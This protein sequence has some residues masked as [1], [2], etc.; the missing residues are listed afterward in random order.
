MHWL[1]RR[2]TLWLLASAAVLVGLALAPG[3]WHI[4]SVWG[5]LGVVAF[6]ASRRPWLKVIA[7]VACGLALGSARGALYL[8]KLAQYQSLYGQSVTLLVHAANDAVYGTHSQLA[9]DAD[10]I[11]FEDGQRLTGKLEVS[12]FGLNTVWQGDEIEVTGK[13]RP[14]YGSFQGDI[15]FAKLSL[16]EHQPSLVATIRRKFDAGMQTALPEPLAPFALGLLIGQ[17]ATL[18]PEIK[19]NLLHV[20][21]THIIAVSGYNLTII[22]QASGGMLARFSKRLTTVLSFSLIGV[23]LL[24]AGSSAS[25]VRAAIV[26]ML[27]IVAKYYGRSFKPLNLILLAAA[28]TAWANPVYIWSDVSWYLSFLAFYGVLVVAPLLQK[29]WP[30]RGFKSLIG[31]VCLETI[32]AEIMSWPYIVYTFGQMSW[33]GLPANVLV[34][35]LVPLA[36]LLSL[37]AGL[38]GMLM[39]PLAGWLAWPARQLLNYMLDTARLLAGIP[40]V[41]IENLQ[42]PLA[43]LVSFYGLALLIG[44]II[45]GKTKGPKADTITDMSGHSKWSTIKREKG[46]KDAARGALFTKLGNAIAIAARSGTDPDTNFALRLAVEKAK[47]SNMPLANI[48]RSIDRAKDKDAAQLQEILYEGYGPG[49]VAILV[50]CATDNINRTYPDVK[51]A[52]AKHGGSIAD[53]GSVAFQFDR[54]GVIRVNGS[55]DD[56]L[57][58]ALDAGAEDVQEEGNESVIY[59]AQTDLAKVR[60]ALREGGLEVTEAELTYVPNNTVEIT[61]KDTAGKIM[62]LMDALDELDDVSNTHVNF[63]IDESLL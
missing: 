57:M 41:F 27:S 52:F 1:E 14:G 42:L 43:G 30:W 9:F 56:V 20:G 48:Q 6:L 47:S 11:R 18:P 21:L 10:Q 53:K 4:G 24:L 60:D 59:T 15:S 45:W 54:K 51:T 46:A 50:E 22:L 13:L 16:V 40:H 3:G 17:R 2:T 12:G 32:C 31:A 36:M 44:L 5:W 23:F 49:G 7:I 25:I 26:S 8:A 35:T 58:A 33:I 39:A 19:Q 34:V 28:A 38:A 37:I 55:G 62:R 63:D 29:R 61:D